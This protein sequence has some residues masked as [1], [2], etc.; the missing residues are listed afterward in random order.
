MLDWQ[1]LISPP[2]FEGDFGKNQID[3]DGKAQVELLE[4]LANSLQPARCSMTKADG[5]FANIFHGCLL[6]E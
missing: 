1:S 5:F 3:F 2:Y 4:L 6:G